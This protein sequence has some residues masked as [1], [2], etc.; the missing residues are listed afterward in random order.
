MSSLSVQSVMPSLL[1]LCTQ[2]IHG[3]ST[4]CVR[5]VAW[6]TRR[7]RR[8]RD[9]SKFLACTACGSRL[10]TRVATRAFGRQSR[11]RGRGRAGCTS[12][13]RS[14][15]A[16]AHSRTRKKLLLLGH[17]RWPADQRIF[18]ARGSK[19]LAIQVPTRLPRAV[20]FPHQSSSSLLC[21]CIGVLCCVMCAVKKRSADIGGTPVTFPHHNSENLQNQHLL[22]GGASAPSSAAAAL[23]A[24][25]YTPPYSAYSVQTARRLL[26]GQPLPQRVAAFAMAVPAQQPQRYPRV[27]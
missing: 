19:L 7:L 24:C 5:R 18:R 13:A 17:G 26:P 21:V 9:R 25:A 12:R 15:G 3:L 10:E 4:L 6:G 8:T 11:R 20:C 2:V 22:A 14:G 1:F 23:S 27:G 16:W